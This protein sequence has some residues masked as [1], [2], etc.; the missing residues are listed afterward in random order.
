MK[1]FQKENENWR[2]KDTIKSLTKFQTGNL[3]NSFDT[4]GKFDY[5]LCRNVLIYFNEQTKRDILE[6][7]ARLLHPWGILIL[8]SSESTLGITDKFQQF[9][10]ERGLY[11]LKK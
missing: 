6:R 10:T 1:Y 5:V 3:L 4:F 11:E 9:G 2:V 8:G 7:I